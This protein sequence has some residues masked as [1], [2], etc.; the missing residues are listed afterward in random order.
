MPQGDM[1]LA[2]FVKAEQ[3]QRKLA[4]AQ[5]TSW[6][7]YARCVL[8]RKRFCVNNYKDRKVRVSQLKIGGKIICPWCKGHD[9]KFHVQ[10]MLLAEEVAAGPC[11]NM[12]I[13]YSDKLR[14]PYLVMLEDTCKCKAHVAR[15][16][17]KAHAEAPTRR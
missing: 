9:G 2:R 7:K 5:D 12:K 4:E 1:G 11:P 14:E 13:P 3:K 15:R 17:L 6:K 8:C 16:V 10:L